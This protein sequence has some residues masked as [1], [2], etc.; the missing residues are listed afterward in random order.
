M[1]LK[2]KVKWYNKDKGFGFL[3]PDDGSKDVFMHVR[4]LQRSNISP[5]AIF[6][7]MSMSFKKNEGPKGCFAT[8][9]RVIG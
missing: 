7:E 3:V 4:E 8:D 6:P 9:L 5:T 1:M 2:G